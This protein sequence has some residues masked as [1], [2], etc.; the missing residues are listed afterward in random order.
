MT[1]DKDDSILESLKNPEVI[2]GFRS[3]NSGKIFPSRKGYEEDCLR[4]YFVSKLLD[5][6]KAVVKLSEDEL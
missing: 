1:E 6:C 4:S 3:Q 2:E 5:F